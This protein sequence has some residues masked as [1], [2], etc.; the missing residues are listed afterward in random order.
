MNALS[1]LV[2]I[3]IFVIILILILHKKENR[4]IGKKSKS[5]RSKKYADDT[6]HYVGHIYFTQ[7]VGLLPEAMSLTLDSDGNLFANS[8]M[9][10]P[11]IIPNQVPL[12]DIESSW[13]GRYDTCTGEYYLMSYRQGEIPTVF[14]ISIPS[15]PNYVLVVAGHMKFK[16]GKSESTD[17]KLG[18]GPLD[19]N[20]TMPLNAVI[21]LEKLSLKRRSPHDFLAAF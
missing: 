21:P 9:E 7:E 2:I 14:N 20:P 8:R 5:P 19:W 13:L 15:Y 17:A 18:F 4:D 6:G 3:I 12:G 1:L 16:N 10:F 11:Q